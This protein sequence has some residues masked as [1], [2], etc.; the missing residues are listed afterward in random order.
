MD[1]SSLTKRE[2]DAR[3]VTILVLDLGQKTG[4]SLHVTDS[5]ITSGTVEFKIA[6]A[7]REAA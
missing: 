5:R 6:T 4:W 1:N 2:P 3:G 7:G